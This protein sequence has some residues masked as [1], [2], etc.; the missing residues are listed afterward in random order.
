MMLSGESTLLSIVF[1]E[2]GSMSKYL[3]GKRFDAEGCLLAL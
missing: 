3:I 2:A 1:G